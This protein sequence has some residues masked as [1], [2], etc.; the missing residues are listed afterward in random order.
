MRTT[1][2]IPEGLLNRAK[3]ISGSPS[4]TKAIILA[5]EE[6]IRKQEVSELIN[7]RGKIDLDIDLDKLRDRCKKF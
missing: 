1:I 7:Y 5:L 2:D 4:K 3:E 6:L